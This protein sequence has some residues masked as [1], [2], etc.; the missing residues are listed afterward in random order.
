MSVRLPSG[1]LA[2]F[3]TNIELITNASTNTGGFTSSG[4]RYMPEKEPESGMDGKYFISVQRITGREPKWGTGENLIDS[5]V[6]VQ[7]S[8][9]RGG[10]DAGEGDRQSVMRNAAD[11]CQI[12]G[13]VLEN[14]ANYNSD[15]TG[16]RHINCTGSLKIH[17]LKHAEV[18]ETTFEVQH[19]S[20]LATSPVVSTEQFVLTVA[21]RTA[22]AAVSSS[23]YDAGVI[24]NVVDLGDGQPA[25]F[26][27]QLDSRT[28]DGKLLVAALDKS[29]YLW[30]AGDG[31]R[32]TRMYSSPE[33]DLTTAATTT[34]VAPSMPGWFFLVVSVKTQT[35]TASGTANAT[36]TVRVG[37]DAGQINWG[38]SGQ[39]PNFA[40]QVAGPGSTSAGLGPSAAAIPVDG[41]TRPSIV[42]SIPASGTVGMT[43]TNRWIWFGW[44]QGTVV[45]P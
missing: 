26:I 14:P 34:N 7:T 19:R 9:Y 41:T 24:A 32:I 42:V 1:I 22:L 28:A 45:S 12:I 38:L 35:V 17:D 23:G 2:Q 30:V 37:N 29:G 31:A 5:V 3:A 10:G 4:Y 6:T 21:D 13:D 18:W 8:Y 33:I 43:W 20:D 44:L 40:Q 11:D 27:L 39:N 36:P 15:V 16:I 25:P